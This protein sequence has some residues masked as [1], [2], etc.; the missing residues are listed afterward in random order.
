MLSEGG[1]VKKE[2]EERGSRRQ[3]RSLHYAKR[4]QVFPQF[5][6]SPRLR[7]A[8]ATAW[9]VVTQ[10]A[11]RARSKPLG[12]ID[13]VPKKRGERKT[14]KVTQVTLVFLA[15]PHNATRFT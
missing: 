6:S 12:L 7:T 4:G 8:L 15:V 14:Q 10:T 11:A 3:S 1:I 13:A 5:T 2:E 9:K